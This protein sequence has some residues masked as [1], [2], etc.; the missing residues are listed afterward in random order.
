[1]TGPVCE[2]FEDR[3]RRLTDA[4]A[5]LHP[6]SGFQE[7]VMLRVMSEPVGWWSSVIP[8]ARRTWPPLLAVFVFAAALALQAAASADETLATA[9]GSAEVDW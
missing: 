2:S 7:Q 9:Y 3:L 1:M 8:L 4:T 5:G 6:T